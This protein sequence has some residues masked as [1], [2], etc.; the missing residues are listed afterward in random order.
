MTWT[1]S[2]ATASTVSSS[3][4]SRLGVVLAVAQDAKLSGDAA[5]G[6]EHDPRQDLLALLEPQ[7]LDVEVGHADAPRVMGG[8]LAVVG[9]DALGEALEQVGDLVRRGRGHQPRSIISIR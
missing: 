5:V 6:L 3:W 7:P 9:R 4:T 1:G 8:V 2:E